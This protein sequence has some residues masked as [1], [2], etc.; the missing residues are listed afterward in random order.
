MVFVHVLELVREGEKSS[1][2]EPLGQHIPGRIVDE[3]V[4]R[5]IADALLELAQV[6]GSAE[7]LTVCIPQAQELEQAVLTM[8]YAPQG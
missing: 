5:N 2:E 7:F 4:I 6:G 3:Y 8:V 1:C